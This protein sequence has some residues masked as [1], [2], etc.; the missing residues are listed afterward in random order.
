MILKKKHYLKQQ[1]KPQGISDIAKLFNVKYKVKEEN[2]VKEESCYIISSNNSITIRLANHKTKLRTWTDNYEKGKEPNK[3]I[4]LVIYG[5]NEHNGDTRLPKNR[6][7]F[8][9]DEYIFDATLFQEED[10]VALFHNI[11]SAIKNGNYSNNPLPNV[12]KGV[13]KKICSNNSESVD[14][15]RLLKDDKLI[16]EELVRKYGKRY[17]TNELIKG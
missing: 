15:L 16:L 12:G 6:K 3:C 14:C 17:V 9:V 2:G 8:C 10:Y 5:E 7:D 1:I 11:K 4:S 13:Y